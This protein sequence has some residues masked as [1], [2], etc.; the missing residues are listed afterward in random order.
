[1][2][3][4]D[5]GIRWQPSSSLSFFGFLGRENIHIKYSASPTLHWQCRVYGGL[6]KSG[7]VCLIWESDWVV[8]GGWPMVGVSE[9]QCLVSVLPKG[10]IKKLLLELGLRRLVSKVGRISPLT[11]PILCYELLVDN[12]GLAFLACFFWKSGP[13]TMEDPF[14]ISPSQWISIQ[15]PPRFSADIRMT[16]LSLFSHPFPHN[17]YLF[18]SSYFWSRELGNVFSRN[19]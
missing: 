5:L 11:P 2:R 10:A 1:M 13:Y 19:R 16:S 9:L 12:L 3:P 8:C 6:Q 18:L 14:G 17:Q 4:W 15:R 7:S